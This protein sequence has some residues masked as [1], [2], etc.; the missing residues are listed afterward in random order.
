MS[1]ANDPRAAA[2]FAAAFLAALLAATPLRAQG[3]A[4]GPAQGPAQKPLQGPETRT[5]APS[6]SVASVR[7]ADGVRA[8]RVIGAAV[9]GGDNTQ[10]GSVDDL[11]LTPDHKVAF[12]IVSVGGV[13]GVGGKLVAVPI[14]QLQAAGDGRF[15]LPG[16]TKDSLGAMPNFVY[17]K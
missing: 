3:A 9:N 2:S 17:E 6:L 11:I 1:T 8:S 12:A 10:L 15:T 13:L 4:Q 7:V 5:G 16:A 14:A